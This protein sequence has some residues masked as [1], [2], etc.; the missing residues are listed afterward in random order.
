[1]DLKQRKLNKA[2]WE[3]I[4]VP[5]S[6][7]E[8]DVLNLITSGYHNVNIKI[9]H[10]N[11]L[12]SFL[13][14]EYSEKME[15]YLYNKYFR[16]QAEK[17]ETDVKKSHKG[18]KFDKVDS[19]VQIKSADKIRLERND[20]ASLKKQDIYEQVLLQHAA[21]IVNPQSSSFVFHYYTL[22]KLIRNNVSGIN[23]HVLNLCKKLLEIFSEA[24]DMAN[25]I[26]TAVDCIERNTSLLKYSDMVLYE[27]QKEIYTAC[28]SKNPKLILYMAPTGT[29]KTLTPIG[30]SE[31]HRVIF[32][33]AARHVG[34]AL[35][36]AAIS[37]KKKIAF[38]FGCGSAADIRLHYFAAKEFTKNRKSGGIGKVDNS[39]G[40]DV[41]IMICDIKSYLPA[42]YYMKSFN[43]DENLIVYWDE[44]TITMDYPEHEFHEIIKQNWAENLIPNMVLS[45]ATLPKAHELDTTIPD[46]KDKFPGA[47]VHNIVS[48]DCK[49]SIPIINKD[50][51]VVLPHYLNETYDDLLKTAAH[52]ENYLT[53]LRYFDLKEVVDF[54]TYVN[55]N[56]IASSKMQLERHFETLD[57]ITMTNIKIYYVK[58]LQNIRP[59]KW[60]Q[61]YEHFKVDRQPRIAQNNSIDAKGVKTK[62]PIGKPVY[63]G[64]AGVYVTTKD[65]NTLT[66]G[67]TI[68]ISD[69]IEKIAKFCIQQAN[70]PSIVMEELM[71]KIE[72]NNVLNSKISELEN[73]LEFIKEQAEKGMKNSVSS[74]HAGVSVQGRSKSSKDFKKVNRETDEDLSSRSEIAKIVNEVNSL[75]QMIK[76]ATLN[77]TFVPNKH[78][79]LA[80]WAE[81]MNATNAFTSDVDDETVNEIMLLNGIDDTWKIL[82][83]MGIG[84]FINHE[85][86]KYTEIMK[87][88]ADEQKL[89][90]I[91][92]SSDYIYGTNYQ[93]CHSYL[94]KDLNLTQEKLIQAM[95]RVGRNNVQQTYTLRFR[96]DHQILKLFTS[97][98]EKPEIM[99]MNKLFSSSTFE[100]S[101]AKSVATELS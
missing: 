100:K 33:C 84:V 20:E 48:H 53:I 67:P 62:P 72:F 36:R 51:F 27:H 19:N 39:I 49:K 17:I 15:D 66:D 59:D 26:G 99:N 71:K 45:S 70:I 9:N 88:M 52:C 18:F 47:E 32:V 7:S 94:S 16:V 5:V 68:F 86:I 31:S 78:H 58:L 79:H 76:P 2:E 89:Y 37:A 12:A 55:K 30:L 93:F 29:G 83:M 54:I 77:D 46:F 42:M 21:K 85:N 28:K 60:S 11:S 3:S 57:D 35:A 90:M 13:K 22:Y 91:I 73:N 87:T 92:A 34:V 38:A 10:T 95:G 69:D 24:V 56:G 44:P 96:D 4:E 82:L 6:Q 50:G 23:R 14:I 64:T 98:T 40:D 80:R 101:G 81:E 8:L 97:D 63:N 41:E 74:A 75:R 61:V 1:M 25:I 43:S 65:A